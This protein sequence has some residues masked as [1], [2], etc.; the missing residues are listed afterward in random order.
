M[1]GCIIV[2]FLVRQKVARRGVT[3]STQCF[4]PIMQHTSNII[5]NVC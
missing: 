5:F 4:I 2:R 3:S 1:I